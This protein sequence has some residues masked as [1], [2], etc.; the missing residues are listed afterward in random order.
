MEPAKTIITTLGGPSAVATIAGVHRTRVSNWMRP[1][2][3]GGTGGVIPFKHVPA[4][5]GAAREKGI[6][7]SAD[8]FLPKGEAA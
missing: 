5:I 4:L 1:K 3:A 8:D 6:S 2:E 7:I